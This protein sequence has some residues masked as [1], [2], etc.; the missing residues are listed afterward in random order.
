M[1]APFNPRLIGKQRHLEH[2]YP[3]ACHS[4]DTAAMT[5]ALWDHY[6][7]AGQR[8]ALAA[9][10]GLTEQQTRSFLMFLSALHDLGKITGGFQQS[11]PGTDP[12]T[13]TP[14]YP[15]PDPAAT[16]IR[17]AQATHL[18]LPELLHR[19]FGLPLS[20]RPTTLLAHQLAQILG[21]HHG[22]YPCALSHQSNQLA[23]PINAAPALGGQSW[24]TQ[25]ETLIHLLTDIFTRP[26]LP[27][28]PAPAPVALVTTGLV[29]LA[30]WL[31]SQPDFIKPLQRCFDADPADGWKA[32]VARAHRAA[33]K[34]LAR[35]QLTPPAWSPH[36]TFHEL[37][38]DLAGHTLHPIQDS[39]HTDLPSLVTGPGMLVLLAQPGDGK[40]ETGLFAER[41]MGPASGT[42]GLAFLLPTQAT[43]D[44]M[45][46]RLRAYVAHNTLAPTPVTLL[47]SLAWLDADYTPD[48]LAA[49]TDDPTLVAEWLRGAH[50]GLLAGITVGTWDQAALAALPHRFTALRWLGLSG[51]TIIIDE[52]HAYDA[53]GH[54]LTLRLLQWLGALAVPVIL[55]SATLTADSAAALVH[56]YR[57]GAGHTHRIEITPTYPGWIYTD[58]ATGTVTTSPALTSHRAHTLTIEHDPCTHTHDPA[59]PDGRAAH[60][61]THLAPLAADQSGSALIVCNTVDDAQA[62]HDLLTTAYATD[63][64]PPLIRLL[65]ARFPARQR[66]AITRRLTRWTGKKGKRP[67]RPVIVITTQIAEQSLDVD[68]DLVITDLAPLALLIQRAGRGHRHPRTDRPDWAPHPRLIVMTPTGQLPPP[69]WGE[70]YSPS[71]LRR[72]RGLLDDLDEPTIN[73]P[74]DIQPLVDKVYGL[75]YAGPDDWARHADDATRTAKAGLAAIP[76]PRDVRDLHLLTN[77]TLTPDQITT[78]LGLDSIRILPTYTTPDGHHWLHPTNHTPKTAL[79]QHID[80]DDKATIRRLMHASIPINAAWLK[81]RAS[82]TDPPSPWADIPVL[83]DLAL[84][85]QAVHLDRLRPYRTRD[86]ALHV[87]REHGLIRTRTTT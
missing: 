34:E 7:T 61:L 86:S 82:A 38:P 22:S 13:G 56:A 23:D 57:H 69:A 64:H 17:H 73:I 74:E 37:F 51:K 43:T 36:T 20:G 71:L 87:S 41:I 4:I 1:A 68:F 31:V 5:G 14:G 79:P 81:D 72:T 54:A 12:L 39:I 24:D 77:T 52:V 70:V 63:K 35:A 78:R 8:R 85:P 84:L 33:S 21:G 46:A 48:D 62:T 3:L 80:P 53:Y 28:R 2:P 16:R 83:R 9:G 26:P 19:V 59:Q 18:A 29:I 6:L 40:T 45:Y 65:H 15:P 55:L 49:I 27:D 60:L 75:E 30:D 50:R 10:W 32:H 67:E 11:I 44:A 58:Q 25:R 66:T 76:A 42:C 47:H